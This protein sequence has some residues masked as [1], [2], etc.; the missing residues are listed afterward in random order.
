M[1][2]RLVATLYLASLVAVGLPLTSPAAAG[3]PVIT[4]RILF[5]DREVP[6]MTTISLS[7][8]GPEKV[9]TA[10]TQGHYQ[11]EHLPPATYT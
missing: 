8:R 3:T 7:G 6:L 2:Q 11:I 5:P 4:A 1:R 10:D 9:T